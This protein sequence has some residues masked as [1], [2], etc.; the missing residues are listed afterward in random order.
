MRVDS[1][2][3]K[4]GKFSQGLKVNYTINCIGEFLLGGKRK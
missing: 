1:F 2:I 3:N 4:S